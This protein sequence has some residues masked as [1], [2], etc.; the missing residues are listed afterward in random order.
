MISL[1]NLRN[2][3]IRSIKER[4]EQTKKDSMERAIN[5]ATKY[6]LIVSQIEEQAKEYAQLGEYRCILVI[7]SNI[8]ISYDVDCYLRYCGFEVNNVHYDGKIIS[9]CMH[10]KE[11]D[12]K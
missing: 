10:W 4:N 3:T 11:K 9:G 6:P 8:N 2:I 12:T 1:E 7:K 5:F